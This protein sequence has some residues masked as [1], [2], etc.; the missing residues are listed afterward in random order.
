VVEFGSPEAGVWRVRLVVPMG[1]E[2]L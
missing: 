2:E 1:R